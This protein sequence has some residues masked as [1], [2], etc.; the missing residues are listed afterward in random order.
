MHD[1]ADHSPFARLASALEDDWASKARPQQLPPPDDEWTTWLILAGRGFGKTRT[2]SE[3][4]RSIAEAGKVHRIALVGPT[5]GDVR[6]TMVEGESGIL[7]ICPDWNRPTYEP[8]KRRLTWPNGCIATMFSSEEPERLR[9]PQHGAA[10]ADELAAW[11]NVEETWSMLQFGLRLGERP[12]QVV[13]TTPKPL[14]IIKQLVAQDGQ[15]VRVT[16]GSTYDN[17]ENLAPTFFSQIVRKYEGTRLGRQELNAELLEDV[18]GALWTR[19]MIESSRWQDRKGVNLRRI[20]V[21]VDPAVSVSETSD[22]TGIV[23]AAI[24]DNAEGCILED[25]SGKYSPTEWASIAVRAYHRWE[26]DRIVAEANQGGAMVESTIR[27]ID[28]N[29]AIT[30][31][32]ASRGKVARAEPISALYENGRVHHV[33]MFAELEDQL[34]SFEPGSNKSPDRLDALVWA[35]TEL[36]TKTMVKGSALFELM[37][38]D[39]MAQA[40]APE[41]IARTYAVG[42]VEWDAEQAKSAGDAT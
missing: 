33:G 15:D 8:S 20:V 41:P 42:S 29:V 9:G 16:R 31:V 18:Q 23:V 30:L 10:W 40:D 38:R 27:V 7:S 14:K 1:S 25:L 35:L 19:D 5:A 32:H 4:V 21:A 3:W 37:R 22:E 2:G 11:R 28:P 6:D 13:T 39:A 36:M 12:R 17:R 34:C 24:D 26:A